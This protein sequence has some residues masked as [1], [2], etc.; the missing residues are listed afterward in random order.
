MFDIWSD[1][2]DCQEYFQLPSEKELKN[3]YRA[4]RNA[5][6]NAALAM[7]TC[8]VCGQ[9]TME[10]DCKFSFKQPK[11]ERGGGGGGGGGKGKRGLEMMGVGDGGVGFRGM[12]RAAER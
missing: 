3:C 8:I 12:E 1:S 5:T 9:E 2:H 10:N 4:F 11:R 6:L 7:H